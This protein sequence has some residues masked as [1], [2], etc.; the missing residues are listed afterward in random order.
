MDEKTFAWIKFS[1]VCVIFIL[2]VYVVFWRLSM[3]SPFKKVIK[4]K[5]KWKGSELLFMPFFGVWV[6]T[7]FFGPIFP[8]YYFG[9]QYYKQAIQPTDK[10]ELKKD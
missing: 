8:M 6:F 3:L 4:E 5:K 1:I 7:V 9:L 10:K 2:Y